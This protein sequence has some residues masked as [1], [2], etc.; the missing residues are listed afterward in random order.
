MAI[1]AASNLKITP[2]MAML[3]GVC[4]ASISTFGFSRVQAYV[5]AKLGLHDSCGVHNL[6]GMPALLGSFVVALAVSVPGT[7]GDVVYPRGDQQPFA[8]LGGA[9]V[10]LVFGLVSGAI[11]GTI[12]K[13]L[14]PHKSNKP[15]RDNA[16]WKVAEKAI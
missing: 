8:Q 6:H 11:V 9:G 3:V 14:L 1:G 13:K 7:Q 5:E 16:W 2:G 12:L 4:A 10:T 15:F